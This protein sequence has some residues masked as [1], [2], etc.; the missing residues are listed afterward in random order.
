MNHEG[1]VQ[2]TVTGRLKNNNAGG[3]I[4]CFS[5]PLG[6]LEVIVIVNIPDEGCFEAPVYLKFKFLDQEDRRERRERRDPEVVVPFRDR[7]TV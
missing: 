5:I 3:E 2:R 6:F 1:L 4:I 7:R